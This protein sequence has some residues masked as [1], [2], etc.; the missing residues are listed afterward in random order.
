M[1]CHRKSKINY[2]FIIGFTSKRNKESHIIFLWF[3]PPPPLLTKKYALTTYNIAIYQKWRW[4]V[5]PPL[6]STFRVS[7]YSWRFNTTKHISN[8]EIF[9]FND[10]I[11]IF[12]GELFIF[13]G[14]I[15]IFNDEIFFSY[16]EI[17]W[18]Y[19]LTLEVLHERDF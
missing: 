4:N 17:F 6:T 13:K 9:I 2:Q 14:E 12:K 16:G 3:S 1:P 19:E 8:D 5:S 11:F 7:S 15:F 18:K 10:E